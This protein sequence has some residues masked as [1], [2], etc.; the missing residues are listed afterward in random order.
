MSDIDKIKERLSIEEVVS[1]YIDLQRSGSTLRARCPFHN[2]KT[3][4][5][6][7]SPDRGMYKCFGCGKSGDIFTFVEEFEGLDFSGASKMLAERAGVELTNNF[8]S[9]KKDDNDIIYEI[10]EKA[11]SF[12]EDNLKKEDGALQYLRARGLRDDFINHFRI[13]FAVNDWRTLLNFLEGLGYKKADIEKAGLIKSSNGKTYD[14]F[15]SRIIF[16]LFDAS[17][18]VIAFSGRIFGEDT[19]KEGVAKYLNS[20]DT[21]VFD[22]SKVLYGFN[23]AKSHIR[24]KKEVIVV[25]GQMDL[26]I[27]HQEGFEN[28]V[29]VSGTALTKDHLTLLKRLADK[30]ILSYDGDSAGVNAALRASKIILGED[31]DPF[32]L[33]LESGLD[34][35]DF[36]LKNSKEKWQEILDRRMHIID[37]YITHLK[38]QKLDELDLLKKVKTALLPLIGSIRSPLAKNHFID[39]VSE[40]LNISKE[41]VSRE[42]AL[43]KVSSTQGEVFD[44]NF[45]FETTDPKKNTLRKIAGLYFYAK[46]KGVENIFT[47]EL[48]E[49]FKQI[50]GEDLWSKIVNLPEK[51]AGEVA[52]EA[53]LLYD[54]DNNLNKQ[55]QELLNAL[56]RLKV[57]R[58]IEIAQN[59][60]KQ[61]EIEKDEE[62]IQKS[63]EDITNLTKQA[64]NLN[65]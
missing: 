28:T 15:R 62:K 59:N 3:P 55:L 9:S 1:S 56:L 25:E 31:L 43:I 2:E 36:I 54:G 47:E 50:E 21:P 30:I 60:L 23:F 52:L 32:V 4:S 26:T 7:I 40:S 8:T 61:A 22:K 44:N 53:G 42:V 12:F 48:V 16:P 46:D 49:K 27:S 65:I 34:P 11:C 57:R 37:F 18:R 35:A 10:L 19:N 51:V 24:N 45:S 5:F 13:G 38:D 29:A 14:R 58:D 41:V 17:S 20:P 6:Y 64:D 33:Y 39:K 63:L